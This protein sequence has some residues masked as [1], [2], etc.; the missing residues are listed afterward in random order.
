[1][2]DEI[3]PCPFCGGEGE[4][5][6]TPNMHSVYTQCG[7]RECSLVAPLRDTAADALAAWNRLASSGNLAKAARAWLAEV[8]RVDPLPADQCVLGGVTVGMIRATAG[9]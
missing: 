3:A 8:E 9:M 5:C 2:T 7:N 1:M 6:K 4:V